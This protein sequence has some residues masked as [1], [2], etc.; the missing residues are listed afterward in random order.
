MDVAVGIRRPV[1]Q[2]ERFAALALRQHFFVDVLFFPAGLIAGFFRRQLA[3][4]LEL[5]I[6]HQQCVFVIH[7]LYLLNNKKA[8]LEKDAVLRGTTFVHPS[9]RR[10]RMRF[11]H[12]A[13]PRSFL[14]IS[15]RQLAGDVLST[16]GSAFH[17]PADS[18]HSRCRGTGA[19]CIKAFP[20]SAIPISEPAEFQTDPASPSARTAVPAYR[21]SSP[22]PPTRCARGRSG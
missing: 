6:R 22:S 14:L 17:Q 19:S 18:L 11:S 8:P 13:E 5:R 7:V 3:S 20:D 4:H 12:N 1:M 9:A 10:G 16:R 2:H 21:P 15:K